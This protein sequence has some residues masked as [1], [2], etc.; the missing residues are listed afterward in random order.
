MSSVISRFEISDHL[1]PMEVTA[2]KTAWL[3]IKPNLLQHST[4][5]FAK[6]YESHPNYLCCFDNYADNHKLHT[7][8]TIV[9]Q[10][11]SD[12]I[13]RGLSES[14][15]FDCTLYEIAKRHQNIVNRFDVAKFSESF[16]EYVCHEI[17]KHMTRTVREAFDKFFKLIESR[18]C[19]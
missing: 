2:L 17:E 19:E 7:H 8:S 4:N 13:E 18:F 11:V 16:K 6:F 14:K 9:V 12:L 3:L 1:T 5:I 10:L 15:F